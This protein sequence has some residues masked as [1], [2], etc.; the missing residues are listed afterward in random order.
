MKKLYFCAMFKKPGYI[1]LLLLLSV[2]FTFSC[3]QYEKILKSDDYNLK[4][5]KAFEYYNKGDYLRAGNIFD[6]IAP[7]FRGTKK[8][9]SVYYFQAMSYFKQHDYIISGHYFQLFAQTF[10][11]SPFVKDAAFNE[12][13]C[14]YLSSPNPELDQSNTYQAIDAFQ[15]FI[16]RYPNSSH[17]EE[18]RNYINELRDKIM[19][20]SFLAA[21]TYFDLEDYKASLTAL[22]TSLVDYPESKYR[23]EIMFMIVKSSYLLAVN[24]IE[25]KKPERFQESVDEYY[26]FIAEFP[27]S[28]YR[29]EATR[30][31]ENSSQYLENR[32]IV[33]KE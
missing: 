12:A 28:K 21:K 22:S 29:K 11:N 13:Y 31:Y 14:Y 4:Y 16:S 33:I 18:C 23:E 15:L 27:E 20:K 24:S 1:H 6:Q 3:T 5:T 17:V 9:D 25:S 2:A 30:M 26:S 8:A 19:Q 10:G 7:V 32:D